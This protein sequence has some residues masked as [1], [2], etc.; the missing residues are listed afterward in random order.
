VTEA[1][2]EPLDI[3]RIGL[4]HHVALPISGAN[5]PVSAWSSAH[6]LLGDLML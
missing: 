6:V 5:G 3:D 2:A 1:L 4:A